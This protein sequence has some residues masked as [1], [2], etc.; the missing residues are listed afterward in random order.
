MQQHRVSKH[1]Y[2]V[3]R[4]LSMG[5]NQNGVLHRSATFEEARNILADMLSVHA[6]NVKRDTDYCSTRGELFRVERSHG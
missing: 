2:Q 1:R 6:F 3:V 4:T 5:F